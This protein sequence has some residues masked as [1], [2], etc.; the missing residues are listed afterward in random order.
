[1]AGKPAE[2]WRRLLV[3]L[4]NSCVSG[5]GSPE[6]GGQKKKNKEGD[7]RGEYLIRQE[8]AIS[9]AYEKVCRRRSRV[10]YEKVIRILQ[11]LDSSS[12]VPPSFG[13]KWETKEHGLNT[14]VTTP[15]LKLSKPRTAKAANL[16]HSASRGIARTRSLLV[17]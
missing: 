17:A 13:G 1:V 5:R 6:R 11:R 15:N 8:T 7:I 10:A 4:Q 2:G 3:H 16:I 14:P 12:P 9:S